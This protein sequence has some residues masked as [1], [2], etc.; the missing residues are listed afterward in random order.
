M[1][2]TDDASD[3][4]LPEPLRTVTPPSRTHPDASMDVIGWLIFL[5]M[6]VLILPVLP[7]I[8]VVWLLAKAGD[9]LTPS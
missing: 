3:S 7:F 8:V 5:G 9:A 1:S 6:V 4:L 2:E